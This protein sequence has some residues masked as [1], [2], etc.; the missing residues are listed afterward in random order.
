MLMDTKV[1]ETLILYKQNKL[2]NHV[3]RNIYTTKRNFSIENKSNYKFRTE[4]TNNSYSEQQ[5]RRRISTDT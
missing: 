3:P 2:L 1:T 5:L 4:I